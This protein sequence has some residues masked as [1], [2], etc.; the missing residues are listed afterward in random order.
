[1]LLPAS[2]VV[3]WIIS[4]AITLPVEDFAQNQIDHCVFRAI[5]AAAATAIVVASVLF[6]I[7]R[8][9]QNLAQASF[10]FTRQV[11]EGPL[12][13]ALGAKTAVF[14]ALVVALALALEALQRAALLA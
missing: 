7:A 12:P 14:Q 8:F 2:D 3:P 9:A 10:M 11:A 6:L 13:G 5:V 4:V 1:M